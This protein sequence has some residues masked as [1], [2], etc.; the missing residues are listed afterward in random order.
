MRGRHDEAQLGDLRLVA[1]RLHQPHL[2]LDDEPLLEVLL[3]P[4]AV[5]ACL[6]P[7]SKTE[8]FIE[9]MIQQLSKW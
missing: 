9:Q 2:Q 1:A 8:S 4:D 5:L 7:R 6:K 3:T